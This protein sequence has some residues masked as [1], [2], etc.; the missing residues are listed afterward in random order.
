VF[1]GDALDKSEEEQGEVL[2]GGDYR[3]SLFVCLL[4]Q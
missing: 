2:R 4:P 3:A 1:C